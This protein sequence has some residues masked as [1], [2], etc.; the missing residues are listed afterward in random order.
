MAAS[1]CMHT[2]QEKVEGLKD[3]R[4]KQ[5]NHL[6]MV[7]EGAACLQWVCIEPTPAP[8]LSDIIPGSE[9]YANKVVGCCWALLAAAVTMCTTISPVAPELELSVS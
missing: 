8:Y 2:Q 6:A 5:F 1:M 4:S 7:A 3:R 9:M